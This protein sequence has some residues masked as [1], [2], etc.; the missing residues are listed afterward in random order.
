M[1]E[2]E[3]LKEKISYLTRVCAPSLRYTQRVRYHYI[4]PNKSTKSSNI[5]SPQ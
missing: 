1:R 3:T 2:N 5:T 4:I